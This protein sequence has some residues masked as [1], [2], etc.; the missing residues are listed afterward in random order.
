MELLL[1]RHG[2]AIEN[3]PG[4]GDAGRWLTEKGRHTTRDVARWLDKRGS[5][6]PAVIWTS[7]LVR[8]VQSAEIIAGKIGLEEEIIVCP[9][10]A[11]NGDALE[12]VR[13]VASYRGSGT[14]A[15]VGHEPSLSL[16]A[17][18]LLG[19][20]AWP[21]LK[22]SGVAAITFEPAKADG[23]ID[24]ATFRFLLRPKGLEVVK[25]I[26]PPEVAAPAPA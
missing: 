19:N 15:L 13:R 25:S 11:P 8:A 5:R 12:L 22:K 2:E 6:R 16:F 18:N 26:E 10:L 9:E 3:A 7:A 4:L 24:H 1:I 20:V 14:L 23:A 21:G 17:R